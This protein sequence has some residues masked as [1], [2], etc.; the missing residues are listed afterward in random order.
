MKLQ[1]QPWPN[2]AG[3]LLSVNTHDQVHSISPDS[4]EAAAFRALQADNQRFKETI[5]RGPRP[6]RSADLPVT[7]YLHA[8]YIAAQGQA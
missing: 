2:R 6:R 1:V 4:P 5:R 3:F 8:E 7:G